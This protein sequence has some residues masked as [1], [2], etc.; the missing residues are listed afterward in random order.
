MLN[1][2]QH[3]ITIMRILNQVQDD[4]NV[5]LRSSTDR[6]WASGAYDGSSILPEDT[7]PVA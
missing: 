1:L 4:N 7:G 6:M 2:F 5:S 3:P